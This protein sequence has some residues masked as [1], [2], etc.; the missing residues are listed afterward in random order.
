MVIKRNE[1]KK[2]SNFESVKGRE[3]RARDHIR[4]YSFPLSPTPEKPMETE[5]TGSE[6]L[7]EQED[8]ETPPSYASH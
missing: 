6:R 4:N 5:L 1:K 7:N 8:E 2:Q 3:Q